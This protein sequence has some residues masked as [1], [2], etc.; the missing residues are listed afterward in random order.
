[1]TAD[2]KTKP[3][4]VFGIGF[5]PDAWHNLDAVFSPDLKPLL[6]E[7]VFSELVKAEMSTILPQPPDVPIRN[8]R[9]QVIAF[10]ARTMIGEEPKYINTGDT[11]IFTKGSEVSVC[12]K[13]AKAFRIKARHRGR[14]PDGCD[15]AFSSRIRR[16]LCTTGYSDSS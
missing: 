11:P 1:M 14:R 8:I 7:P 12:T 13:R 15:S 2:S 16:G 3:S 10:S 5:S 4:S 6:L 9:G